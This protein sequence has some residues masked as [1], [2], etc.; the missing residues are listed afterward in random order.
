MKE[1][2]VTLLSVVNT[3]CFNL[4]VFQKTKK[5][6]ICLH[7]YCSICDIVIYA[8]LGAKTG[9]ANSIVNLGKNFA[10]SRMDSVRWMMGFSCLRIVLLILGYEGPMTA[11]FVVLEVAGMIALA[12]GTTQQF[13]IV[14]LLKQFLWVAY[15]W[16]FA[17]AV[18]ACMTLTGAVS[19]FA[20][21][22][23]NRNDPG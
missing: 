17:T 10:Y 7:L 5:Q 6:I 3:A 9:I 21:V 8:I 4:S 22:M 11:G 15:D 16:V 13:R 23:R 2:V 20:A 14:T 12:Y 18:I 1:A 19:C